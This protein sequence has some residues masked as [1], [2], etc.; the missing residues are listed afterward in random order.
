MFE[1]FISAILA[2]RLRLCQRFPQFVRCLLGGEELGRRTGQP[3]GRSGRE[4]VCVPPAG[5]DDAREPAE[6]HGFVHS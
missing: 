4:R 6:R 1:H 3:A 2:D 5:S